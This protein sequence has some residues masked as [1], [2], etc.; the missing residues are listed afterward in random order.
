ME[1][2][3]LEWISQAQLDEAN[4]SGRLTLNLSAIINSTEN[5]VRYSS[6]LNQSIAKD[7]A[8]PRDF[9]SGD[10]ITVSSLPDQARIPAKAFNLGLRT[11]T[12]TAGSSLEVLLPSEITPNT[13]DL[14]ESLDAINRE[15][16]SIYAFAFT[17]RAMAL[18]A[19]RAA[20]ELFSSEILASRSGLVNDMLDLADAQQNASG[21][22]EV[23]LGRA[24]RY[25]SPIN[26]SL[27]AAAELR[28]QVKATGAFTELANKL[29]KTILGGK[30]QISETGIVNFQPDGSK[31]SLVIEMSASIIKSLASLVFYLRHQSRPRDVLIIDEPELNLHPENQSKLARFL[32]ELSNAGLDI[33]ISTHSDYIIRE[34]NNLILLNKPGLSDV[35]NRHGYR[36][37]ELMQPQHV[38][39]VH[40]N[41]DGYPQQIE[42][43]ED[44]FT[45]P[46]IDDEIARQNQIAAEIMLEG[47]E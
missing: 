40:F 15:I 9:F 10:C 37:T 32:C 23:I 31:Q 44:G 12:T 14:A 34:I 17:P 6:Q 27:Q 5:L 45:V 29:E 46:T 22:S 36:D 7:F 16:A 1:R 25:S 30:V 18:T 24:R 13:T 38:S 39:V 20:I 26:A 3:K 35:K 19:E 21:Y 8:A 42:V 47:E 41:P 11:Y 2:W 33:I 43:G 28:N 4:L